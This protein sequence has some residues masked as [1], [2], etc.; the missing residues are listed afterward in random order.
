[1]FTVKLYASY[2]SGTYHRQRIFSAENLTVLRSANTSAEITL[3]QK[4]QNDDFC[5]DIAGISLDGK[6]GLRSSR[7]RLTSIVK[8]Q[9]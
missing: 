1:M 3:H 4:N 7:N 2:E 9:P 8:S 6:Y 5:V